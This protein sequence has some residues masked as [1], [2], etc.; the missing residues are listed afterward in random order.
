VD[1]SAL[2][3]TFQVHSF[4]T[5]PVPIFC[6][7]MWTRIRINAEQDSDGDACENLYADPDSD[8]GANYKANLHQED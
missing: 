6:L 5:V 1:L 7:G 3:L 4:D 8:P 2:L